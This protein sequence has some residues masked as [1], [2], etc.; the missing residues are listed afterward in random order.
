MLSCKISVSL[1]NRSKGFL[2]LLS[3]C[4]VTVQANRC[5]GKSLCRHSET[6][7]PYLESLKTF[8]M[9]KTLGIYKKSV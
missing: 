5:G 1:S 9:S 7:V 6:Q 3:L 2:A 4:V 8:R